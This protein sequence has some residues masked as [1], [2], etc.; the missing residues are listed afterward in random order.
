[1]ALYIGTTEPTEIE[2]TETNISTSLNV[3]KCSIMGAGLSEAT[4]SSVSSYS[5]SSLDG[6]VGLISD[7]WGGIT[8]ASS[9]VAGE[10]YYIRVLVTDTNKYG[11]FCVMFKSYSGQT[12]TVDNIGWGYDG[13]VIATIP[14]WGKPF[15]LITNGSDATI[16]V[17]RVSSQN[18]HASTDA[19]YSGSKIYYGD[20]IRITVMP[21]T[22]QY[23]LDSVE[24]NDVEQTLSD[25]TFGTTLTVTSGINITA[26]AG[27]YTKSWK[28][29][30]SGAK[31]TTFSYAL[32]NDPLAPQERP[33]SDWD[34]TN[35]PLSNYNVTL[36]ASVNPIRVTCTL[37][38]T[39]SGSSTSN[40]ATTT[41]TSNELTT[42]WVQKTNKVS[43]TIGTKKYNASSSAWLRAE[44]SNLGLRIDVNKDKNLNIA[45]GTAELT[46]TKVEQYY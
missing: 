41:L 28:T 14:V 45:T 37:K 44:T 6:Y 29:T 13:E 15:S 46:V 43:V 17:S 42:S 27:K 19:L 2:V 16:F 30:F 4:R 11:K 21:I 39:T 36:N 25:V 9:L 22:P 24:I 12:I 7:T 38:V 1:M 3:L 33:T 23:S 8:N 40:S 20:V 34:Y 35:I 18:Q 31:S 26:V 5:K 32:K 10:Y